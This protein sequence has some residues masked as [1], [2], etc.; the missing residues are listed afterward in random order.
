MRC[1][2][3]TSRLQGVIYPLLHDCFHYCYR[4]T[5]SSPEYGMRAREL[6]GPESIG[7]GVKAMAHHPCLVFCWPPAEQDSCEVRDDEHF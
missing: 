5:E 3:R 2:R 4:P 6:S 1:E 7:Q